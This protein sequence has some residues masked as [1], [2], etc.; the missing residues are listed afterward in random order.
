MIPEMDYNG[1]E[2]FSE[3]FSIERYPDRTYAMKKECVIT[4]TYDKLKAVKQAVYKILRTERY[5]YPI[6]SWD[7]GI[8]LKDLFGKPISYVMAEIKYRIEEALTQDDRIES[9]GNFS[10]E[11]PEK[12]SLHVKFAVTSME[13][14][15]EEEMEVAV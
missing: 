2:E 6:Y 12:H 4:G 3:D 5:E 11:Q 7:Y 9:V 10:F 1:E 13:G 14:E 8:E 15:F